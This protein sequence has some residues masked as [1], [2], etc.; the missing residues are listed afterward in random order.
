MATTLLRQNTFIVQKSCIQNRYEIRKFKYPRRCMLISVGLILVG[1]S[2]PLLMV[3]DMIPVNLF[4]DFLGFGM[5]IMGSTMAL[6]KCGD[7]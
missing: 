5:V 1:I 7:L 4:L 3:L 2:V 6:I